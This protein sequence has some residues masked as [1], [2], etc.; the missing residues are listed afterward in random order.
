VYLHGGITFE[1]ID[2]GK[3]DVIKFRGAQFEQPL[4]SGVE[5]GQLVNHHLK[6]YEIGIGFNVYRRDFFRLTARPTYALTE[7]PEVY[8][9]GPKMLPTLRFAFAAQFALW[10]ERED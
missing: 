8:T 5:R 2:F 6:T 4:A 10:R 9:N 7:N 1:R 3:P